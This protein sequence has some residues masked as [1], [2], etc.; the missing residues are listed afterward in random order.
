ME[1]KQDIFPCTQVG[2][3]KSSTVEIKDGWILIDKQQIRR[4]AEMK[5]T[6]LDYKEDEVLKDENNVFDMEVGRTLFLFIKA[7]NEADRC[8]T[9]FIGSV[10]MT[11]EN[12]RV[13]V[14]HGGE[15][16]EVIIS[17]SDAQSRTKR[18]ADSL[19][20]DT[21]SGKNVILLLHDCLFHS[22]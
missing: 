2:Y 15:P 20:I 7:C 5:V 1:L 13:A 21:P 6:E 4:L 3:N 16:V 18:E 14:S 12:S 22:H 17:I 9:N 10:V 11:N 8:Q 19:Q